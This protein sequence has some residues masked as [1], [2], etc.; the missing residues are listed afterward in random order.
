MLAGWG[1]VLCLLA[2]FAFVNFEKKVQNFESVKGALDWL[3]SVVSE[4]KL[5]SQ[6][7]V[8]GFF[9]EDCLLLYSE[10]DFT[11]CTKILLFFRVLCNKLERSVAALSSS[12]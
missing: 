12:C 9:S 2:F 5:S 1:F 7:L 6:L 3:K 8:I 4:R 11:L 10:V